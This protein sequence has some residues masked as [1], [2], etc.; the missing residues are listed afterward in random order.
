MAGTLFISTSCDQV[1][2][3]SG[4]V[5]LETANDTLS[6]AIGA[7]VARSLD[8]Q[9]M[10]EIDP[11]IMVAAIRDILI[12]KGEGK[13]DEIEGNMAIREYMTRKQT[14]MAQEQQAKAQENLQKAQQFLEENKA[15]E[16]IQVMESGLQYLV[17]EAGDGPTPEEG[18]QVVA[19]YEGKL[20]DGTVFDSSLKRG[21]PLTIGVNQVIPGW[22]EAL[23]N[24]KVGSKWRLFIPPD[25]GYG[26]RGAGQDIGP[27]EALIFEV[28]LLEIVEETPAG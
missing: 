4:D 25:L 26:V 10:S 14:E 28:E 24:M 6:Y 7:D 5:G 1:G 22:T 21:E 15:K 3:G 20:V 23:L 27:N 17:L 12:D 2:G 8:Q 18:D 9:G 13:L 19:H 11:Q 16:G